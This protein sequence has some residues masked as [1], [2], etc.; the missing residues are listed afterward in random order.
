MEFLKIQ[1]VLSE[2]TGKK[3]QAF[4]PFDNQS[5]HGPHGYVPSSQW[6][7]NLYDKYIE[8]HQHFFEQYMGM[9]T[10]E[11][12]AMDHSFKVHFVHF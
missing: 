10:L 9:L 4:L 1:K 2:W 3:Y 11:V 8:Q 6:I 12:G 5:T 7:K